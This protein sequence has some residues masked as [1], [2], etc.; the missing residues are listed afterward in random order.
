ML[1]SIAELT[2]PLKNQ[3]AVPWPEGPS[4]FLCLMRVIK[5]TR[6]EVVWG[7]VFTKC[8]ELIKPSPSG[9]EDCYLFVAYAAVHRGSLV[10]RLSGGEDPFP[11]EAVV[12][13]RWF[14][15]GESSLPSRPVRITHPGIR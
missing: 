9:E 15:D 12:R 3:T 14:Q 10:Q 11:G 13:L 2:P 4:Y 5:L 7:M 1:S 8:S 6:G